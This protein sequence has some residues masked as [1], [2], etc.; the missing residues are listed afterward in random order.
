MVNQKLAIET[1]KVSL[2]LN[3]KL[4]YWKINP[5]TFVFWIAFLI[6]SLDHLQV[7][8]ENVQKSPFLTEFA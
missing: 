7:A 4:G 3:Q 1:L 8:T 2:H 6:L 5:L